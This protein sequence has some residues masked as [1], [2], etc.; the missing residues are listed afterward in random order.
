M[1]LAEGEGRD[2]QKVWLVVCE[3]YA[4]MIIEWDCVSFGFEGNVY[5]YAATEV[6]L[7]NLNGKTINS[8][9]WISI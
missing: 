1:N 7:I 4:R 8:T 5:M 9:N 3:M 6:R 2:S